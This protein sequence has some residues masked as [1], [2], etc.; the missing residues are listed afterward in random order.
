MSRSSLTFPMCGQKKLLFEWQ[1]ISLCPFVFTPLETM[2]I[3]L[4]VCLRKP[5]AFYAQGELNT[6]SPR[7]ADF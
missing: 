6:N 5:V 4:A 1:G 7:D 3:R 2:L